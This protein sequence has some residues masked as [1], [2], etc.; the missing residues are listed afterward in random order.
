[1]ENGG[2]FLSFGDVYAAF[3]DIF[4]GGEVFEGWKSC[5]GGGKLINIVKNI[6]NL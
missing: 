3:A 6:L 1:M 4:D 2:V 5:H